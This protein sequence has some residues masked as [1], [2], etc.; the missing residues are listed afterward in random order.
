[1]K[2]YTKQDIDRAD[3]A[4]KAAHA[5]AAYWRGQVHAKEAALAHARQEL[6]KTEHAAQEATHERERV[7]APGAMK[8]D[9]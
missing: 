9:K 8:E 7:N 6:S 1:M 5:L 3:A 4:E 2:P